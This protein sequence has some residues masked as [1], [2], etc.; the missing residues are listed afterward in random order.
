MDLYQLLGIDRLASQDEIKAA[1]KKLALRYHPDKNSGS[2]EANDLFQ[3]INSA[4]QILSNP[5]SKGEYDQTLNINSRT[6]NSS[7]MSI[8]TAVQNCFDKERELDRVLTNNIGKPNV[9]GLFILWVIFSAIVWFATTPSETDA[10]TQTEQTKSKE[11]NSIV[12]IEDVSIYAKPNIES[13]VKYTAKADFEFT[14]I[15]KT[16]Y[17]ALVTFATSDTTSDKGYILLEKIKNK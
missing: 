16:K 14:L 5:E 8:D 1:Y 7:S 4:Y 2:K 13:E 9:K 6:K 3:E 17:F 12:A 10:T 15:K 11:P